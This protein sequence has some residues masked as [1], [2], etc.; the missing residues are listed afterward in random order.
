MKLKARGDKPVQ[1]CLL[2]GHCI[3]VPPEGREV[4]QMFLDEA[5]RQGCIPVEIAAEDMTAK[6]TGTQGVGRD[7]IIA[8]GIKEMLERGDELTGAGLPNLK[9]LSKDVG[10]AVEREEMVAIFNR[11]SEEAKNL[12]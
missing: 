11:L 7:E 6:E 8:N 2:S 3:M 5:F 4:A 1:V 9:T 10:F 12:E